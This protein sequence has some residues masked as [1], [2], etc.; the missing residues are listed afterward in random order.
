MPDRALL[1]VAVEGEGSARDDAYQV[2]ATLSNKVDEVMAQHR[3]AIERATTTSLVVHP[4]TRWRKGE[5]VRTG[6]RAA[7]SSVLE[8]TTF[9]ALGEMIAE[10]AHAGASVAGP[11]FQ[12]DPD[13]SA[14]GDARR[15]AAMDA[16]RRADEYAAGLGLRVA[17]VAWMA[18]P[19]LRHDGFEAA[20]RPRGAPMAAA[21]RAAEE[22][23]DVTPEEITITAAV[24][25]GFAFESSS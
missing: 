25:V 8:L 4:K 9:V 16:R 2:A 17:G 18:E 10:L 24:E 14:F 6:W 21:S 13:N 11:F 3:D 22:V 1:R 23:I 15:A 5:S 20:I 12:L 7:R 19:G